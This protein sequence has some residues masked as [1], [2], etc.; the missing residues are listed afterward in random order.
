MPPDEDGPAGSR[1]LHL[2]CGDIE[3]GESGPPD[4]PPLLLI[5]GSGGGFDQ[6]LALGRALAPPGVRVIASSRFGY[7]RSPMPP[8]PSGERQA[9]HLAA[10]LDA[11]GLA[12]AVVMGVSAGGVSALH[13]AV[14]PRRTRALVLVV[15]AVYRPD[16]ALP[17]PDW[18]LWLL[19]QVLG[20]DL[21]FRLLVRL[22]CRPRAGWCWPR[23]TRPMR[24]RPPTSSA[25]PMPCW[26]RSSR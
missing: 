10:L 3:L 19:D 4:G 23:R 9:D 6:G 17:T 22:A 5:H 13:F 24:P 7:L 15:P 12:D 26:R 1:L 25:A 8:D 16:P 21:P 18:A 11:L 20:A 2:G 14:P